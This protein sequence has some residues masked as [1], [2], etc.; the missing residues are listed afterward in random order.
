MIKFVDKLDRTESTELPAPSNYKEI[1][2]ILKTSDNKV[3]RFWEDVFGEDNT[4][5]DSC[6][7][8]EE[9]I[10]E[11]FER[12]ESDFKFDINIADKA[13]QE[14]LANFDNENWNELNETQKLEV[15][16][17]F[18]SILC[19]KMG[20]EE[21]PRLFLFENDENICGAYNNQTN[22]LELN[23]NILDKPKE[24][25]NTI[26]H[27]T[28]HAYQYQRACIGETREDV[29]Y[30]INFLNYV[31]P[32]QFEGNYVNFNEYQNQLIEAEARAFAKQFSN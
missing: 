29:L 13:I 2:P 7:T 19:E 12:N 11:I 23:R 5:E 25:I 17:D 27:E 6:F 15:I 1:K 10:S 22:I 31:E 30:A 21:K 32:I 18:I 14:E 28:R 26:A 9:I 16:D 24:V 20:G 4:S 3:Q 8:D